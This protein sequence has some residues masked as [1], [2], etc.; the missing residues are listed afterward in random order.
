MRGLR[1]LGGGCRT[2]S[3]RSATRGCAIGARREADGIAQ[4]G[5]VI[6]RLVGQTMSQQLS[7][8]AEAA[9]APHQY[10]LSTR[11]GCE[12]TAHALQGLVELDPDSDHC[13]YRWDQCVRLD[14]AGDDDDRSFPHG[15][16]Q[17]RASI[18]PHVL[19]FAFRVPVVRTMKA[20][21]MWCKGTP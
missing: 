19:R 13:V 15:R 7:K 9:T 18:R 14:L 1:L 20:T 12:C 17:R 21:C 8:A 16:R 5:D 4:A 3:H 11:A 2:V 10:A 6:R